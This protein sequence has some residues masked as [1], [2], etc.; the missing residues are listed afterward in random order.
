MDL[1]SADANR[2]VQ[3]PGSYEFDYL[4][5]RRPNA[6]APLREMKPEGEPTGSRRA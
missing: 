5:D 3:S 2:V 1:L 4:A 6:Y